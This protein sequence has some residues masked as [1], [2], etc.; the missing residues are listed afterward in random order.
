[1]EM[2]L[3]AEEGYLWAC[4]R[5]W[6]KPLPPER[7]EGLDWDRV[8]AVGLKNRMQVLVADVFRATGVMACLSPGA[9][10]ELD[11]AVAKYAD[12]AA[13]LGQDLRRY[14]QQAA[15]RGQ[16]VVVLK[17]LWLSLKIYGNMAMR[18][19][20]DIDVLLRREDIPEALAILEEEMDYG[21]WWRPLLDDRYYA[22]HHLHQQRCNHDRSIWFEPHWALDHPYTRL[23]IDYD[24]LMDRTTA[25]ELWGEPARE[26][27]LPDLLISLAV[28]LVKH[29]VYLP[30]V[31]D[32]PDLPRL[33]LADGMLMY[34]LDV[35]EVVKQHGDEIDWQL[36]LALAQE[37]GVV[38][39][40]G[41]VLRVCRD[42]LA[43]PVPDWALEALPVGRPGPVTRVL[44]QRLADFKI[45]VYQG[46]K[47][48]R[49]WTF[50][51]GYNE[52]LVFRPIRLLDL[53]H[54]CLP[55][56]GFLR[57]RY[58]SAST[59]TVAGHLLRALGQYGRV[60][61]DT[62]HFSWRRRREVRALDQS[63]FTWP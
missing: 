25:G 11:A 44:M 39:I 55:G 1:M 7:P 21:R 52:S 41:S 9:Q 58:G 16:A 61:F 14:L 62:L 26:M 5:D 37:G 47:P 60:G 30:A 19:G 45:A 6:R 13:R 28:H 33:I 3:T 63:G 42:C 38:D 10:A 36:A 23:T 31:S 48:G 34:F 18:P 22:R 56:A 43:A 2:R 29:A 15:R 49:V 59:A 35:A 8:V 20:S 24:G 32:R 4:G 40:L 54:Y 46:Q 12:N 17:G 57:R 27:S 51:L 50:L 53:A